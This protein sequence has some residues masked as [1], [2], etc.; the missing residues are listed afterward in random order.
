MNGRYKY[1]YETLIS[2]TREE[3][4]MLNKPLKSHTYT[5]LGGK[6]D[7][8]VTPETYEQVQAIVKFAN[9]AHISFTL[10]GNGSNLIIKDGGIRGIVMSLNKLKDIQINDTT[11]VA[12]SGAKIIDVSQQALKHH[13][14][15]LEFACGIPGSVGGALYMNAGAYG[16]EIKDVLASAVVVDP[17]GNIKTLTVDDLDL[18]YRTSNIPTKGYIVLEATFH[19][20]NGNYD[21]IKAIM[22]DLTY[23]RETKQPLEYPSCGSVF[24]RPPGYYAG[25]LIQDSGLQGKRIGGAEVSRKH[26]GFIVNRNHATAGEYIALI[27]Y[28]QQTVKETFGVTLEREVR[29]IGEDLEEHIKT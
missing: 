19:L 12:Q 28:V 21:H 9:N 13:L 11:I 1:I 8:F 5:R 18:D 25:K 16:G 17:L 20:K 10:L 3:N 2:M 14:T 23:K 26:A 7:F 6:A 22:D 15:G 29:I 4:V 24:K 27:E